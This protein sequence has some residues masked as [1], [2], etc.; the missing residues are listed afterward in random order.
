MRRY[1]LVYR[2]AAPVQILRVLS[3]YRDIAALLG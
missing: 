1:L 2:A 3:I